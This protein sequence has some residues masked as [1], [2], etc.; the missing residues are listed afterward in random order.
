MTLVLCLLQNSYLYDPSWQAGHFVAL[1][2][3]LLDL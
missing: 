3:L 1:K 2:R